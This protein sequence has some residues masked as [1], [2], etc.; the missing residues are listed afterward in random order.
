[1]LGAPESA[2]DRGCVLADNPGVE[3]TTASTARPDQRTP[4]TYRSEPKGPAF[5]EDWR[6]QI[7]DEEIEFVR[8]IFEE[9]CSSWE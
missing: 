6:G 8:V 9:F 4:S 7:P 5:W 2:V 3:P 1:M